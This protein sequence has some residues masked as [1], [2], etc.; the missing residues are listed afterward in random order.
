MSSAGPAERVLDPDQFS[1]TED[2]GGKRVLLLDDTF[3]TGAKLFSAAAALRSAG[4]EVVGPVVIGR[5]VQTSWAPSQEMMSWLADRRWDESRCCRC[6]GEQ[7][8]EGSLF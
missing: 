8:D 2:V 3:T 7:R 5:H 4:A 6:G 1:V